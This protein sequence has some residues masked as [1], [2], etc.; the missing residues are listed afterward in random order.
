MNR[1]GR[2]RCSVGRSDG[3]KR[4]ELSWRSGRKRERDGHEEGE[5]RAI[6]P[7]LRA[8]KSLSPIARRAVSG[9]L[10]SFLPRY[11][12]LTYKGSS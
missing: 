1:N 9:S 11:L 10:P 3:G 12:P 8:S 6:W 7:L 2:G 5:D 4:S